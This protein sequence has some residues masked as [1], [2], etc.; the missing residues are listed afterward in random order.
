V[1]ANALCAFGGGI[2]VAMNATIKNNTI[3]NNMCYNSGDLVEAGGIEVEQ[4]PGTELITA[5]IIDNDIQF[6]EIEGEVH[7]Y[8]AGIFI[9]QANSFIS[10]NII[11]NNTVDVV[12]IGN[13][14][15]IFNYNST[16][17]T[18]I[19]SNE[20]YNNT[21]IGDSYG[22]A[23]GIGFWF[24]EGDIVLLNNDIINNIISTEGGTGMRG[25]GL[26]FKEPTGKIT[27][28]NNRFMNNVLPLNESNRAGGGICLLDAYNTEVIIT[29]NYFKNNEAYN[30]GGIYSRRSYNYLITNNVFDG[31]NA[32]V[33]GGMGVYHPAGKSIQPGDH[34]FPFPSRSSWRHP[35][36]RP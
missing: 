34:P 36:L 19:K 33:G 13:G 31:N 23:A 15:G 11:S 28:S 9:I 21:V 2:Y 5:Q 22:R 14:G 8:G 29:A 18:H 20:I 3:H 16:E 26:L 17:E 6:N 32:H 25:A 24:P 27:V 35:D 12:G 30:G 7:G 1:A 4:I 10:G